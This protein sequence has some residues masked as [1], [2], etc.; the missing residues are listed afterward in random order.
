MR[1]KSR[2]QKN[3]TGSKDMQ[4]KG[5]RKQ[6]RKKVWKYTKKG[7]SKEQR[8]TMVQGKKEGNE[9]HKE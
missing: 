5:C 1:K 8:G 6:G 3:K 7:N 4:G 9:R 2:K